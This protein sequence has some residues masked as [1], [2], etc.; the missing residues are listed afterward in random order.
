MLSSDDGIDVSKT[1]LD[2]EDLQR[3]ILRESAESG[4]E[5]GRTICAGREIEPSERGFKHVELPACPVGKAGVMHGGGGHDFRNPQHSL[6]DVGVV[7]FSSASASL[8]VGSES[9]DLFVEPRDQD[10][11]EAIRRFESAL[12][13]ESIE[14]PEDVSRVLTNGSLDPR[15]ARR[16]TR[17][18]LEPLFRSVETPH[19]IES[20]TAQMSDHSSSESVIDNS[21]HQYT[22][23][24]ESPIDGTVESSRS[25]FGRIINFLRNTLTV[26]T[27]GLKIN[28]IAILLSEFAGAIVLFF[29]LKTFGTTPREAARQGARA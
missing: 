21:S 2:A 12:G 14:S 29:L 25:I 18:Q 26:E 10:R 24:V 23:D 19:S 15:E 17:S 16:R 1:L 7:L 8:V 28:L 20:Q 5:S 3:A 13:G 4:T 9:S 22:P 27:E 11:D 6:V